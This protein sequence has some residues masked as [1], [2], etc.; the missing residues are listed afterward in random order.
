MRARGRGRGAAGAGGVASSCLDL[1]GSRAHDL[2]S[3][4]FGMSEHE[5]QH[6]CDVRSDQEGP[7]PGV[8]VQGEEVAG[9]VDQGGASQTRD[10]REDNDDSEVLIHLCI[11]NLDDAPNSWI[12]GWGGSISPT[13]SAVSHTYYGVN[14]GF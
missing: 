11:D 6:H 8:C 9:G 3:Q 7:G 13:V 14:F 5:H 2:T 12:C 10:R 4:H 1:T